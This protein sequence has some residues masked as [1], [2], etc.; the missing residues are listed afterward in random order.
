MRWL[1]AFSCL[2]SVCLLACSGLT[3]RTS[4][5]EQPP[6][7]DFW[8]GPSTSGVPV[9]LNETLRVDTYRIGGRTSAE[10]RSELNR[11]GPISVAE[12]RRFDALT[13]WNLRWALHY[14]R[15]R[16]GCSLAN[17]TVFLDVVVL[18]PEL[19]APDIVPRRVLASWLSYRKALEAHEMAHVEQQ[20]RGAQDLQNVL[21]SFDGVWPNCRALAAELQS[22]GDHQVSVI[23][24]ADR[25]YDESTDHGRLEGAVFP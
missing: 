18:L 6:P 23:F 24:V 5:S 25:R 8:D 11:N 14:D 10:I 3:P 12:G 21:T 1:L 2:L 16:N 7:D 17:A 22:A 15:Q 19:D 20:R 13:T 4:A 9:E